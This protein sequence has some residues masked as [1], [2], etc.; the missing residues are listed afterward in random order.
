[1][2]AADPDP[3]PRWRR[4]GWWGGLLLQLPLYAFALWILM[5]Y[6]IGV[7]NPG[8]SLPAGILEFV[9]GIYACIW[10]HELGH[11]A[12]ALAS[13]W[14]VVVFAVRPFAFHLVNREVA[15]MRRSEDEELGGYVLAVPSRAGVATIGRDAWVTAGGPLANIAFGLI[16]TSY[17]ISLRP[18]ALLGAT[19]FAFGLQSFLVAGAAL[20]PGRLGQHQTD[21]A[22]LVR[23]YRRRADFGWVMPVAWLEAL[24]NYQVRLRD[25]P[26]WLLDLAEARL[27]GREGA[28]RWFDA[29]RIGRMLDSAHMDVAGARAA[30]DAYLAEHGADAWHSH[31]DVYLAAVW[32]RDA[33]AAARLWQSKDEPFLVP[34]RCAA[35]AAVAAQ[36][37]DAEGMKARLDAMDK[38]L[39]RR[40]AFTDRT[41]RDI[42]SRIEAVQ[43]EERAPLRAV[44]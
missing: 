15:R 34:L 6:A 25:Q 3:R 21:G 5:L 23:L 20:L 18:G 30:L 26:Q 41:F 44:A 31:C 10:I 7:G 32:E 4:L 42:R 40:S 11:A 36:G 28:K 33:G 8:F 9:L 27:V 29:R 24:A 12:A 19:L 39:R 37:G 16:L 13:G 35:E 17:A 43:T 14:R 38:A 1:M 2:T 22:A